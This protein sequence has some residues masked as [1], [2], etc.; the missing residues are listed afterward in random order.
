MW[1]ELASFSY[2]SAPALRS[3]MLIE[4]ANEDVLSRSDQTLR[5]HRVG[6]LG[7]CRTMRLCFQAWRKRVRA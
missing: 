3:M 4:S 1:T 2:C 7:R 6:S 5:T